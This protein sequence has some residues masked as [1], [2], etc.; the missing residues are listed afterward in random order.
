NAEF[1]S[2]KVLRGKLSTKIQELFRISNRHERRYWAGTWW[3]IE[4][5]HI[6][7]CPAAILI[8]A[9]LSANYFTVTANSDY[10]KFLQKLLDNKKVCHK[11][12]KLD[13]NILD[14]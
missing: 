1:P 8:K 13:A 9:G 6:T 7:V 12:P 2:H 14:L 10:D 5:L 3:L 4:L 11:S